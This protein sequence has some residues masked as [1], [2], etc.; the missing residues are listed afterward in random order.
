[1]SDGDRLAQHDG[2]RAVLFGG[3]IDGPFYFRV[4]QVM[5]SDD[6]VDVDMGEYLWGC[7]GSRGLQLNHAICDRLP[8]F[9]QNGNDI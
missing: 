8:G 4:L 9:V 5:A 3:Q 7:L 6:V 1:M 2:R